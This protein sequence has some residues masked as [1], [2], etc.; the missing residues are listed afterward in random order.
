MMYAREDSNSDARY[1]QTKSDHEHA[2][3]RRPVFMS[4]V[5]QAMNEERWVG[6]RD[7]ANASSGVPEGGGAFE[8][9]PFKKKQQEQQLQ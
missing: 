9:W 6:L 4:H 2:C 3:A 8:P 7:R 5:P 1:C